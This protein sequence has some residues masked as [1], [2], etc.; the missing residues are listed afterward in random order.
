[1]SSR[2]LPDL[3]GIEVLQTL[4][5]AQRDEIAAQCNKISFA[6]GQQ[7]TADGVVYFLL[8]G[9]LRSY[10]C[11][12]GG[13][14]VY[15][16]IYQAGATVNYCLENVFPEGEG[17]YNPYAA[18]TKGVVA[19]LPTSTFLRF[20]EDE[21]FVALRGPWLS[22]CTGTIRIHNE[23]IAE[24]STVSA[25]QR[26]YRELCRMSHVN[27]H[28]VPEID[29]LPTAFDMSCKV[30]ATRETVARALGQLTHTGIVERRGR[31]LLI[32]DEEMLAM[33]ADP[34]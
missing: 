11:T 15:Y 16:A 18:L 29:N 3:S 22:L 23:R 27:G 20:F 19:V 28:G 8:E 34:E 10:Y 1:M 6:S 33:M 13:R 9:S 24:L 32:L 26:I 25:V 7:L 5:S 17:T 14:S 30:G 12:P 2:S 21:R 4:S 31:T